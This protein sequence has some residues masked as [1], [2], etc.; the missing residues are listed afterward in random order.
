MNAT[1]QTETIKTIS[2]YRRYQGGY[3]KVL[4]APEATQNN[5]ALPEMALPKGAEPPPHIH[6]RE[7]ESFYLQEG[8]IIFYIGDKTIHAHAGDAVFAP[9]R[10]AHHFKIQSASAKFLNLITPGN[11]LYYFLEFSEPETGAVPVI[12]PQ[13]PPSA[14]YIERMTGQLT[15]TYGIQSS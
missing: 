11:L 2:G 1:D 15:G 3:F 12:A 6:T 10:I 4:I 13:G 14:A 5:M 9:R 7:D 8:E